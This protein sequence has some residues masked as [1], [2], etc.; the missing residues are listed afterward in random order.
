M[1]K[2]LYILSV[3]LLGLVSC[4]KTEFES[5]EPKEVEPTGLVAV[6]MK[7]QIPE[8]ELFAQTKAGGERSHDPDIQDI[9]V[10]VFG[11]SGYP[12]AYAKAEPIKSSTDESAG[13]YAST[14]GDVYYFKVLLPVYDA[15][16]HVH[17]IANGPKTIKFVDEDED[18]IMKQMRSENGIGA[19]WARIVMP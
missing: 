14:N 7:I 4:N 8:V 11:T 2:T 15:E 1:K 12:Q 5:I 9:R 18:S 6:T 19:F 3:L 16:A 17:I 13:S 10:A